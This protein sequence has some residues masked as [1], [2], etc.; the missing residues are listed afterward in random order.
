M[1]ELALV[2]PRGRIQRFRLRVAGND[3][4]QMRTTGILYR[5]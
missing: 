3:P 1:V 4:L 2:R 5:R